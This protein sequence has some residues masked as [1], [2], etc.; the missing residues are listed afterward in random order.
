M[1]APHSHTCPALAALGA[2][3]VALSPRDLLSCKAQAGLGSCGFVISPAPERGLQL[4]S[5]PPQTFQL[6]P[7]LPK[8][9]QGAGRAIAQ[10][11]RPLIINLWCVSQSSHSHGPEARFVLVYPH[12]TEEKTKTE[13]RNDF[14]GLSQPRSGQAGAWVRLP[15]LAR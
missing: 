5:G 15:E 14:P 10:A 2:H 11:A 4:Q 8:N 12:F 3:L 1:C 9:G 13:Q 7:G 6:A